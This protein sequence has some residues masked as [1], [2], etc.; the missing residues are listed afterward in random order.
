MEFLYLFHRCKFCGETVDGIPKSMQFFKAN[1]NYLTIT[2]CSI[3]CIFM[4][5]NI[6]IVSATSNQVLIHVTA[7]Y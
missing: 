3:Q 1:I 2:F 6:I 7:R 4:G 5:I